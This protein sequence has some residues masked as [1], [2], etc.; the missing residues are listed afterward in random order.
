MQWC[1]ELA[2]GP[3][4]CC[5]PTP[6]TEVHPAGA[7]KQYEMI[8]FLSNIPDLHQNVPFLKEKS[9]LTFHQNSF[10]TALLLK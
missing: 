9:S 5:K 7:L 6:E 4:A 1:K 2:F 3:P 10:E 8:N